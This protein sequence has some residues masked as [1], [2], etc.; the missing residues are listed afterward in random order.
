MQIDAHQ[1][2]WKYNSIR[3]SWIDDSMVVIRKDFLPID[4]EPILKENNVDGCIAV[5]ADQSEEET[6]FLLQQAAKNPF[7]KG[8]VGWVDLCSD[9]IEKRVRFFSENK[10]FKGVRHIVQAEEVDFVLREDFQN[11]ISTLKQ[12]DLVYEILIFPKQLKS[13]IELVGKFPKQQFVLD[14]IAKP[15]I[16]EE[17]NEEWLNGIV[18]LS[19]YLNVSCKISGMVTETK[20]SILKGQEFKPFLDVVFNSFGVDR[21]LY[22]SDWPVCLLAAEYKDVMAII[23]NYVK[24]FS[25]DDQA[26]IFGGNAVR[27]YNL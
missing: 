18:E 4:L 12:F 8:V 9:T 15:S 24:N 20:G 22:G 16:S 23:E 25:S 27:I 19:K 5:Q 11:G 3:D 1:H 13:V 10:L 21:I 17:I 2:F 7:V 14:H 26:M 6:F